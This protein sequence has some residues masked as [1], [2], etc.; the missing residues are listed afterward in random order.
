MKKCVN[1]ACPQCD[2]TRPH[3]CKRFPEQALTK[4]HACIYRQL[5]TKKEKEATYGSYK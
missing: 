1:T 5:L 2:P 3:G 4:C